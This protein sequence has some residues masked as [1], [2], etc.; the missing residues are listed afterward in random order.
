MKL[1]LLSL[2]VIT[3]VIVAIRFELHQFSPEIIRDFILSFGIWGPLVYIF[4]YTV[5]PLILFPS[6][7]L[8]LSGGYAFGPWWGTLY[9]LIGAS[10]GAYLAFGISRYFGKE[11]VQRWFGQRLGKVEQITEGKGF[12]TILI[13]RLIPLIPFDAINYGAGLSKVSFRDYAIATSLGILPAAFAF[14][15]LGHSFHNVFSWQFILAVTFVVLLSL[16]A[17]LYRYIKKR[18]KVS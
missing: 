16:T 18:K 13:L 11:A 6:L 2:F 14:N 4:L 12:Q 7:I 15:N 3:G 5:R 8:T 9:D 1:I 10:L 17:P